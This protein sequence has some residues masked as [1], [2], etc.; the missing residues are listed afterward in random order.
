MGSNTVLDEL[1][2][3]LDRQTQ[4]KLRLGQT[5]QLWERLAR[6]YVAVIYVTQLLLWLAHAALL[7]T[8]VS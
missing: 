6:G 7:V 5:G 2:V 4:V 3:E 1:L 8:I